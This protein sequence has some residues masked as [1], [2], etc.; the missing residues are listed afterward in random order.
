VSCDDKNPCTTDTVAGGP[1]SLVQPRAGRPRRGKADGCCPS[2]LTE[3]EDADCQPPCTPDKTTDCIDLCTGKVCATASL[4]VRQVQALA[5]LP[6]RRGE[7]RLSARRLPPAGGLVIAG[8]LPGR[9]VPAPSPTLARI[10]H[11][12]SHTWPS[13]A[14]NGA[15]PRPAT[16]RDSR[17]A[18]R[19]PL[20]RD[21]GVALPL[22]C[23]AMYPCSNPELVAAASEAGALGVVQP[24]SIV[25]A[26][27]LDF[28]R[29]S[30]ASA[31]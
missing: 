26:H 4:R 13:G 3:N 29:G 2:G 27:G 10:I 9:A 11:A 18:Q 19:D 8:S 24:M 25:F 15:L 17:H 22:I 5:D 30:D 16:V 7:L 21:A 31:S 28:R 23:G 12:R 20:H 6:E 14:A 1:A